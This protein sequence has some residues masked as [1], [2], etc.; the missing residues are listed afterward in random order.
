[1]CSYNPREY[2][3]KLPELRLVIDQIQSGFFSPLPTD[4]NIHSDI[5]DI[6]FN[7]NDE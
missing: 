6:I 3:D 7:K 4:L 2:Y 1:L 5:I